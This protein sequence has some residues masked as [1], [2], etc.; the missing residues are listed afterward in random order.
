M[1]LYFNQ[2]DFTEVLIVKS[3][4]ILS[5]GLTLFSS[6]KRNRIKNTGTGLITQMSGYE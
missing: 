5:Y 1:D 3:F 6:F 2:G 4:I